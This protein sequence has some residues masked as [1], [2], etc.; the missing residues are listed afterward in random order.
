MFEML[1]IEKMESALDTIR[2]VDIH[3][4]KKT[5]ISRVLE[6]KTNLLDS[7]PFASETDFAKMDRKVAT[8]SKKISQ[9]RKQLKE[10]EV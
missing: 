10:L 9:L 2:D 6:M 5:I 1:L 4:S 7:I 8:L 3:R